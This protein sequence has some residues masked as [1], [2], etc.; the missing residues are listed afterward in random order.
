MRERLFCLEKVCPDA[1]FSQELG[2]GRID[3]DSWQ[4]GNTGA[5]ASGHTVNATSSSY[6]STNTPTENL[7]LTDDEDVITLRLSESL[8]SMSLG[9]HPHN[10]FFGK[11]SGVML[12]RKAIDLKK[13]FTGSEELRTSFYPPARG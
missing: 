4:K 2:G 7:L 5:S 8:K 13:E 6:G 10:R 12:I 9:F 11:S 1:D 3:R